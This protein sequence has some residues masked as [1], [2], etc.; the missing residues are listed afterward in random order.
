MIAMRIMLVDDEAMVRYLFRKIVDS[1]TSRIFEVSKLSEAM[2]LCEKEEIDV[3]LLD[4]RLIDATK[5]QTLA[6]IPEMRRRANASVIVVSG[7]PEPDIKEQ[8]L[9][10]GADAFVDKN[11]LFTDLRK[12]MLL[13]VHAAVL[14]HPKAHPGDD[15]LSHVE[16]LERLVRAAA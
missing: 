16:M 8:A 2:A 14:K 6:A 5:I 4:L 7:V 13:A 11:R 9:A 1:I 3:I 15:Y 10:A 12:A